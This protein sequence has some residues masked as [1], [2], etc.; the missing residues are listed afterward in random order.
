MFSSPELAR[1]VLRWQQHRRFD[2]VLVFCSSMFPYVDQTP[3][4]NTPKVVDLVDVDS[5]K[6]R[7][8]SQDSRSPKKFLYAT[9]AVRVRK[10]ES[11]IANR[12]DALVLVSNHEAE[13]FRQTVSS[14]SLS[15]TPVYGIS[16]GVD[17]QY[18]SP[19]LDLSEPFEAPR[20]PLGP[21]IS[22][23]VT[24]TLPSLSLVF[25]GVLDYRPNVEGIDW[26]CKQIL[27]A[28]RSTVN[29]RLAIVG[30]RPCKRVLDLASVEGVSVVGEVPD[31]R[32]YLQAAD[33]A[34]SPLKL[35]RGIQNKVLEAMAV[36]LPVVVTS[37][38][39]EGI[40]A[41]SGNE[42]V[43]ADTIQQWQAA[44]QWMASAP[45][46]RVRMGCAGRRLVE[47]EYSWS[48]RLAKFVELIGSCALSGAPDQSSQP[49][50]GTV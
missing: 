50:V 13:L 9:E 10:L 14:P 26:F 35:A 3:F 30:R 47:A 5:Q 17:T 42:F 21:R 46:E 2:A 7:Q 36:A 34:I 45:D 24:S 40:D 1:R 29:V 25:T 44:L 39:A 28:M 11:R 20:W 43:I 16:N 22:P 27:P 6:W 37:Q 8:M 49:L 19:S 12:S 33:V 32:P 41:V 38:S 18:F 31:V 48:A 4:D 23:L 15:E